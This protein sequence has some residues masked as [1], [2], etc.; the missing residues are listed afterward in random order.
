MLY[1]Q[2]L[3]WRIVWVTMWVMAMAARPKAFIF[4]GVL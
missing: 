4:A 1:N 3:W 2:L